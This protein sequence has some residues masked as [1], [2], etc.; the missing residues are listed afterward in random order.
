MNIYLNILEM[1]SQ[2]AWIITI[3]VSLAVIVAIGLILYFTFG[4]RSKRNPKP[5]IVIDDEFVDSL[6]NSLGG[7]D[8]IEALSNDN[9]RVKFV[10]SDLDKMDTN[11]LK[12][13]TTNGLFISG[14]NV[15]MLF[16]YDAASVISMLDSRGVK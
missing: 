14:K 7:K 3:S 10:I 13:L 2:I 1:S 15:K 12:E 8:N 11:K 5:T 4:L 6:L 9:G 16:K